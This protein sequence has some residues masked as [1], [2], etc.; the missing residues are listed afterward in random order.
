[1]T[2][3]LDILS[4][5]MLYLVWPFIYI[6]ERDTIRKRKLTIKDLQYNTK[7]TRHFK[8]AA[9]SGLAAGVF[10]TALF[11]LVFL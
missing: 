10:Y 11:Y 3:F 7:K 8:H 2:K 1:M 9:D 4:L 6:A 5:A